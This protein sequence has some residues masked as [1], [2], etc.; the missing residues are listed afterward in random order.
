MDTFTIRDLRERT[1]ELVRDAEAGQ[2]SMV[3]K[4]GHPVF[5]A[6]PFDETMLREGVTVALAIKLFDSE[7]VSL[8]K[9][10][11]LAGVSQ[12][13]FIDYLGALKIPVVRYEQN[14][15]EREVAAFE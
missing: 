5:V 14:E 6:V 4:H 12:S 15:L 2:L 13:E 7:V 3:T 1:G 10:A 11:K 9:A 8:G